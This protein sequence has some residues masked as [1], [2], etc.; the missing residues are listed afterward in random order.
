MEAGWPPPPKFVVPG[1]TDGGVGDGDGEGAG[2]VEG[3]GVVV[4]PVDPNEVVGMYGTMGKCPK[5]PRLPTE[6]VQVPVTPGN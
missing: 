6:K 4:P 1:G 3:G 2:V 5:P